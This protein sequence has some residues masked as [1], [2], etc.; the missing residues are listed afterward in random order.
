[1]ALVYLKG[2]LQPGF[3]KDGFELRYSSSG[4]AWTRG[5][6]R[7][8]YTKA[9]GEVVDGAFHDIVAFN[10]V[11]EHLAEVPIG[12]EL[13][14]NGQLSYD[15]NEY[16]KSE[17]GTSPYLARIIVND[18][19]GVKSITNPDGSPFGGGGATPA[20]EEPEVDEDGEPLPF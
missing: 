9:D 4:T 3:S 13:E 17:K 10:E 2:I 12:A 8:R 7:E 6:V 11:A 16:Y 18:M 20:A 15:K 19:R 14:L 5:S 1:M